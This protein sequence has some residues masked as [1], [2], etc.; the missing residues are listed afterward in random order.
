MT[1]TDRD[2]SNQLPEEGPP[3]QAPDAAGEDKQ[4]PARSSEAERGGQGESRGAQS[5]DE[6]AQTGHPSNA[7]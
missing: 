7:G 3:G 2:E 5:G 1:E 4:E 6:S